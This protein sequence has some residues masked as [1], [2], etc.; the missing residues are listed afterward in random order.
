MEFIND[1]FF[2]ICRFIHKSWRLVVPAVIFFGV[3]AICTAIY[4]AL[5]NSRLNDFCNEFKQKFSNNELPCILLIN[6]FSLNDSTILTSGTN[7]SLTKGIAYLRIFLWLIAGFVMLLRCMLGADFEIEEVEHCTEQ[8][9][10]AFEPL[11]KFIDDGIRRYSREKIY[12]PTTQQ[13]EV[14]E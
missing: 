13:L 11:S 2:Y 14:A 1:F 6:R 5:L 9:G 4:A 10:T 7:F 12:R 3:L 8:S